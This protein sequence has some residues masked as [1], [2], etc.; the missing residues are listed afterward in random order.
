VFPF[1][2]S[3]LPIEALAAIL[4][5]VTIGVLVLAIIGNV[6]EIV[7]RLVRFVTGLSVR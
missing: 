5:T 2:Y 4:P 1:D 6:V 3:G 7:V